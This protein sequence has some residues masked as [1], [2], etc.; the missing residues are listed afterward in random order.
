VFAAVRVVGV[1]N[2]ADAYGRFRLP[3][4]GVDVHFPKAT[5]DAAIQTAV[6]SG[7]PPRLRAVLLGPDGQVQFL[8]LDPSRVIDSV[9]GGSSE[10]LREVF[11]FSIKQPGTYR[12]TAQAVSD[13]DDVEV[14]VG[15]RIDA[16]K[17]G[18]GGILIGAAL[19]LV[20][21]V[22]GLIMLIV[23]TGRR[24]RFKRSLQQPGGWGGPGTA[25][26]LGGYPPQPGYSY[27][28]PGYGAPP[29]PGYGAPPPPGSGYPPAPGYGAPPPPA[30]GYGAPPPPPDEPHWSGPPPPV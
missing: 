15:H 27:P 3:A 1:L 7:T 13:R 16:D 22:G 6:T 30:P 21:F 2:G 8:A 26:P 24:R 23:V 20:V 5:D 25:P 28:P 10:H 18:G 11:Y 9:K 29:P 19:G 14:W 4:D 17:I 12:L